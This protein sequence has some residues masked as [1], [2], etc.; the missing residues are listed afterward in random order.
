MQ[1][2]GDARKKTTK[3]KGAWIWTA[4]IWTAKGDGFVLLVMASADVSGRRRGCR[5]GVT[6]RSEKVAMRFRIR[7]LVGIN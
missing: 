3:A 6:A 4:K 7:V 2:V 5:N 1:A